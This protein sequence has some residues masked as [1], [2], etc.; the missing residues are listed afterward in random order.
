[1]KSILI[2]SGS[3]RPKGNTYKIMQ[4]IQAEMASLGTYTYEWLSLKKKNLG[5]CKGCLNCM[6]K[7]EDHCPCRDDALE[8]RDSLLA[9]DGIVFLTP[10]Y[11]HTVSALLK[12]MYD[13]FAWCCHRP[14]LLGKSALLLVTTELSGIDET[15]AYMAFPA[16]V[17]GLT[18]AD[19][20]GVVYPSFQSNPQYSAQ[21]EIRLQRA[22]QSFHTQLHS[23]KRDFSMPRLAFFHLM[24][25]KVTL[26]KDVLPYDYQFWR[27]NGWLEKSFYDETGLPKLK[28]RI[29][30]TLVSFRAS[31]MLKKAGYAR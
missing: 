17:W 20:V 11:V 8:I 12:N 9:A 13:R 29:A 4:R 6:K 21:M 1:M 2:I 23:E 22:A 30:R 18:I 7:S 27:D 10:V 14:R 26:H 28:N 24:K 3:P 16:N 5:Y 19:A 25:K 15:L 31:T